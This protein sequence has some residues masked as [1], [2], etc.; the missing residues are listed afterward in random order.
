MEPS[1]QLLGMVEPMEDSLADMIEMLKDIKIR[2]DVHHILGSDGQGVQTWGQLDAYMSQKARFM[3]ATIVDAVKKKLSNEYKLK[4][5]GRNDLM[6]A[7]QYVFILKSNPGLAN[8]FA[9]R[10]SHSED[11]T[12]T[13]RVLISHTKNTRLADRPGDEEWYLHV[14]KL[15]K[16]VKPENAQTATEI[17]VNMAMAFNEDL[18]AK[19]AGEG[20]EVQG[21]STE[22][23]PINEPTINQTTA[24]S[25]SA[26]ETSHASIRNPGPAPFREYRNAQGIDHG[27]A[28]R[29]ALLEPRVDVW[30]QL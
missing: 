30:R 23:T 26:P 13:P 25:A 18:A 10:E 21:S 28:Y 11:N 8:H 5:S 7:H 15:L 2:E 12:R 22:E 20:V 6:T 9:R 24:T 17:I 1:H 14:A 19:D 4:K 27:A 16:G 29:K 3:S